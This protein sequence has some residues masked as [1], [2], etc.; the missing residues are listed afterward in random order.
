MNYKKTT[1]R[2]GLRIITAPM[3][4][5][6][7]ATVLVMAGTGSR[8]EE[9]SEAGLSH[10]LEHMFFKG[11]K[12]RPNTLAIAEELDAIGGEFNAFTGKSRTGYWAKADSKHLDVIIDVISDMY[13]NSK[14]ESKEIE[15]EK[16]TILQE[17]NMYEDIPMRT[18][19]DCFE[20][21]L[22]GKQKLG[23]E[24]IG[25]KKTI[26]GFQRK[27]FVDYVKR[28]Y[29]AK[30]TV[31]CVAGKIDSDNALK[32]VKKSFS[33]VNIGDN[34]EI[35]KVVENQ[36]VPGVKI[37]DKDTDQT[38]LM[39]GVRAYDMFH[40]D[41]YALSL[42]STILGGSMSSRLFISVRERQGLA[43]Y[44][45]SGVEARNDSGYLVASAGVE[46]KNLQKTIN[47]ILS[48]FKKISETKVGKTE[49][50]KAKDYIKGKTIMG[51]ES[52]DEVADFLIAQEVLKN[53][54][55]KPNQL[56]KKIDKVTSEDVLRV[57]K[58][59]FQEKNL[60]LAVI[61]PH[62]DNIKALNKLLVLR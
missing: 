45:R 11:T 6:E 41:K 21:L 56:F 1:L 25:Y 46:H 38:H 12:K 3:K 9:E 30:N 8:Y 29:V 32:K 19:E 43:Y 22:Y 55:K 62:K 58:D 33:K 51:L 53:E 31:I 40:K 20:K 59:I 61:G 2:N 14:L 60:N 49:L 44:V 50:Q 34:L 16:G 36:K 28:H 57:A 42:L 39:L 26:K 27:D 35:E 5:T 17:L 23:R 52:S 15:R 4:G 10:F 47:T 48:E 7:T 18:V 13:L 54:I 24:I 37:K